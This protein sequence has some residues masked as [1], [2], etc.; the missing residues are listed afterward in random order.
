[1]KG[2]WSCDFGDQAS[3]GSRTGSLRDLYFQSVCVFKAECDYSECAIGFV[4]VYKPI[5]SQAQ[6]AAGRP[7]SLSAPQPLAGSLPWRCSRPPTSI[8][9]L[10]KP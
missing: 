1:M 5:A 3:A 9:S 4:C 8:E 6:G 2:L 10:L 7:G